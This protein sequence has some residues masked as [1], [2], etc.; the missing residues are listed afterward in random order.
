MTLEVIRVLPESGYED[1][2]RLVLLIALLSFLFSLFYF[3]YFSPMSAELIV[4][5]LKEKRQHHNWMI[6]YCHALP[7]IGCLPC[8]MII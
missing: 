8:L 1:T 6:G 7:I 5:H 4:K 3:H 2:L